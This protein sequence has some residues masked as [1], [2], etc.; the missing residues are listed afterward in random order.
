VENS[1]PARMYQ[2]RTANQSRRKG[3]FPRQIVGKSETGYADMVQS[4]YSSLRPSSVRCE[5]S[6][7]SRSFLFSFFSGRLLRSPGAFEPVTSSK[8]RRPQRSRSSANT[9]PL[10]QRAQTSLSHRP[11]Q[12]A[13]TGLLTTANRTPMTRQLQPNAVNEKGPV[14]A[15]CYLSPHRPD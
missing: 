7:P 14:H 1:L 6:L 5:S 15:T 10:P 9:F 13:E 4:W 11:T 2:V 3:E 12:P 8:I